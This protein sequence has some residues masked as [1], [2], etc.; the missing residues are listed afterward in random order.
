M[1]RYITVLNTYDITLDLMGRKKTFTNKQEVYGDAYT[2][3]Y[4]QYFKKIGEVIGYNSYLA[5]PTF[6]PDPIEEFTRKESVRKKA[7][8]DK[9]AKK[10]EVSEVDIEEIAAD[11][12][13]VIEEKY[14]VDI[15]KDNLVD[16][17]EEILD[18]KFETEE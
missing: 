18:V 1:I 6:I 4:P 10:I 7:K 9:V 16:T 14:N 11:L 13:E 5:V 12:E 8:K 2:K 3:A 17:I 15:D